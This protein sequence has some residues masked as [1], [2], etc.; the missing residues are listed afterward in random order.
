[1]VIVSLPESPL[2]FVSWNAGRNK[3]SATGGPHPIS[4][5]TGDSIVGVRVAQ[6]IPIDGYTLSWGGLSGD[7]YVVTDN[8]AA[9]DSD[10]TTNRKN[11]DLRIRKKMR[12][13]RRKRAHS[14]WLGDRIPETA[15]A[16]VILNILRNGK[17]NP[18]WF[19]ADLQG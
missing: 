12:K 13:R 4:D 11:D 15:R 18:A 17:R 6:A 7:I 14:M 10:E 3:F 5:V 9:S 8:N 1:M 19:K 16:R 2:W